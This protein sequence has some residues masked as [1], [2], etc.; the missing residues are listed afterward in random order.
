[1]AK[2]EGM[3][4]ILVSHGQP[5]PHSFICS[6]REYFSIKSNVLDI[7]LGV[8]DNNKGSVDECCKGPV[9]TELLSYG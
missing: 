7:L 5:G 8:E 4:D 6:F 9:V 1:M 3:A 2:L